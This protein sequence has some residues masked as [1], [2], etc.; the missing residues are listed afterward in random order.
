MRI[1]KIML[2]LALIS[3]AIFFVSLVGIEG[4][5]NY[6]NSIENNYFILAVGIDKATTEGEK[7]KITIISEKFSN[8]ENENNK[9]A[10]IVSTEGETVLDALIQFDYFM[11]KKLFW[12]HLGY[13][14][15]G[16]E[17]AKDNMLDYLDFFIRDHGIRYDAVLTIAKDMTA[18]ELFR[19]TEKSEKFLP[20]TL[21]SIFDNRIWLSVSR[22]VALSEAIKIFAN[23]NID[24]YLPYLTVKTETGDSLES[25]PTSSKENKESSGENQNSSSN[26]K[27]DNNQ[28]I[29]I[30][31]IYLEGLAVFSGENLVEYIAP[32]ESRALNFIENHIE[33]GIIMVKDSQDDKISTEIVDSKSKINVNLDKEN[34]LTVNIDI[35]FSTN[36]SEIFSR[37]DI[38]YFE[39]LNEL[40]KSQSNKIKAQ[41]ESLISIMKKNKID[42]INLNKF[43]N[44]KYPLRWDKLH[45]QKEDIINNATFNIN[46]KSKI[47]RTY[48]VK[49]S[50][51]VKKE[52]KGE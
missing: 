50:I 25:I 11:E 40:E 45:D 38:F 35:E 2:V 43:V 5:N 28:K 41:V 6:S 48:H 49:E 29:E 3:G 15:I 31:R 23:K 7:V 27:L 21:D 52:N 17:V 19:Q 34:K 46:V 14:V 33:S 13:I 20:D 10:D 36:I 51:R 26:S 18:E 16:D 30:P 12:G 37:K 39:K 9:E 42:V 22:K 44:L 8:S 4:F 1:R 47:N 32:D 24:V